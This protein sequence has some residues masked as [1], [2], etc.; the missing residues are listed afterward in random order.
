MRLTF[1]ILMSLMVGAAHANTDLTAAIENVRT[2]CG[3][4]SAELSDMKKMAGITTAVT[5]VGTVAGGVALGTGLAKANVDKEIEEL[6]AQIAELK[7]SRSGVP[8]EKLE[9][10]NQ[11]A[12]KQSLDDF[13]YTYSAELQQK[14]AELSAAEKKSKQ[15][16]NVRTGT[17]A[18]ATATNIA[19]AVMSGTNRVK[20]D[21]KQQIDECLAS[22]KTLSNVRMQARIDGSA[23]NTDLARA[24]N[25]IRACDAWTTVDVSSI[26]KRSTGA[27]VSSGIGAGLGLAG[28][29]TSAS[30][31]SD[32]VRNGDD[33][34]KEKNLNTAAN[35]LAGGTTAAGLSATIFNATQ[36]SA[37]KRAATVADECEGA[38]K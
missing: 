20:G 17:M 16:G 19:G 13:V 9:I 34:Q 6:E 18:A 37:I 24:E 23:T 27:T 11:N 26:N 7:K 31:N 5:G 22:V 36:I 3:N 32:G 29:I 2:V 33:K 35:V 14:A 10:A 28:T 38:L 1:G 4:I 12:F 21:L 25:I 30:A 8:V 15:L